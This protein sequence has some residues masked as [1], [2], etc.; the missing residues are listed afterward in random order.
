MCV[1]G[2]S[3]EDKKRVHT[4]ICLMRRLLLLSLSGFPGEMKWLQLATLS[5]ED[6]M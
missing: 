4:V 1:F 2:R 5:H 3:E 6:N